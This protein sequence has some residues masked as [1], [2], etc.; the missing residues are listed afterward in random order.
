MAMSKK[1]VAVTVALTVGLTYTATAP[2]VTYATSLQSLQNQ[3]ASQQSL[4]GQVSAQKKALQ[5]QLDQMIQQ[6]LKLTGQ[7]SDAQAQINTTNDQISTLK[8]DIQVLQKRIDARKKLLDTRLVS[9]YKNGGSVDVI[10][11]LLGSKSFGDFIDRATTL[12]M[13]TTQDQKIINDQKN[14]QNAVAVKK[15]SVEKKQAANVAK[16]AD[17]QKNLGKVN[18]LQAQKKI[19]V[20]ALNDKQA[21]ISQT[22]TELAGAA[23]NLK[24]AKPVA[25]AASSSPAATPVSHKSS[26]SN[27]NS[28]NSGSSSSFTLS[29]SVSSGGIAGILNY[30]NQFIGRSSYAWGVESPSTGRFDCSGFV[31]AAF[32]ANGISLGRTTGAQVNEGTRVSYSSARPG[33]LVFFDTDGVNGHVGI[34]LGGGRFIGSQSSTGV[35]VVSMSNPYWSAHFSGV[36]VRILN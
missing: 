1:K 5:A 3:T 34:Y 11:F 7:I 27:A 9:I 19:A 6:Q 13:I 10:D 15:Q 8:N 35:A 29:S 18:A 20:S 32:A 30:G 17:L 28:G 4:S 31:Q 14:D 26:T 25:A 16:L 36:V 2:S 33:D 12:N 21:N 22:L 24:N 23:S